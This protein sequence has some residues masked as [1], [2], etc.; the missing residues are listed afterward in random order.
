M[1][2][3][4]IPLRLVYIHNTWGSH[5]TEGHI[6]L[7]GLC[8]LLLVHASFIASQLISLFLGK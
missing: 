6:V 1:E 3:C 7:K 4:A 5:L 8:L 2:N